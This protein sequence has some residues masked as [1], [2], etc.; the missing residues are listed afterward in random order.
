MT[1]VLVLFRKQHTSHAQ[2]AYSNGSSDTSD[3]RSFELLALSF[4]L[5]FD[6]RKVQFLGVPGIRLG[7][8]N[9]LTTSLQE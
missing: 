5:R 6:R 1:N 2:Q 3:S 8:Q 7:S 9:G 4:F